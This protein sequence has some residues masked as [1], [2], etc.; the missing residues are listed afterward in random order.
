MDRGVLIEMKR[1]G[2]SSLS[3]LLF[4]LL[5]VDPCLRIAADTQTQGDV[6]TLT[7]KNRS[8]NEDDSTSPPP[9]LSTVSPPAS[10]HT[11]QGYISLN[12]D[13]EKP[14]SLVVTIELK[15]L[16]FRRDNAGKEEV[17]PLLINSFS[18]S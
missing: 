6:S 12:P 4:S 10:V 13:P 15:D 18:V 16:P 17:V 14:R 8:A 7:E 1:A 3:A 2:T 5:L 11:L 9:I